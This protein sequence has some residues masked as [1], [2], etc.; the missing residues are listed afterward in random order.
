MRTLVVFLKLPIP[1]KVKTRL[2]KSIGAGE[3]AE[4]YKQLVAQVLAKVTP[5][6]F[7][8]IRIQFDPP[9]EES[10]IRQW[11]APHLDPDTPSSALSPS[12]QAAVLCL[13]RSP[14]RSESQAPTGPKSHPK[15]SYHPQSSGDLGDRLKTAFAEAFAAGATQ[16]AAIGTDCV[17]ITPLHFEQAWSALET[18]SDIVFGPANDGGYYLVALKSYY[19]EIFQNIPWSEP[20]TLE[21]SLQAAAQA[22]LKTCQLADTLTDI[23]TIE[24]WQAAHP[25]TGSP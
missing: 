6:P 20:D 12:P 17:D 22:N 7:D 1:G 11:L 21:K 18:G 23:D 4:A 3:A 16:A 2:A 8:T 9:S 13:R 5:G 10:A 15:I 19:P 25:P 14:L 24:E